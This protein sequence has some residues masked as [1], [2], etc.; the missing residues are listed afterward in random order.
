MIKELLKQ[1][2]ILS[3]CAR[4]FR[5]FRLK[6]AKPT[7]PSNGFLFIGYDNMLTRDFE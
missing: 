7:V 4:M 3:Y 6:T 1:N 2:A 5:M